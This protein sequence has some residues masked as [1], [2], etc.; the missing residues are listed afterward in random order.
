[1]VLTAAAESPCPVVRFDS[2]VSPGAQYAG[3]SIDDDTGARRQ[4]PWR[5]D[6]QLVTAGDEFLL[7]RFGDSPLNRQVARDHRVRKRRS[8]EA[9]RGPPR[10]FDGLLNVHAEIDHVD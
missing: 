7:R 3:L 6:M 2:W 5:C 9:M 10:S 4:R 8:R 1:M